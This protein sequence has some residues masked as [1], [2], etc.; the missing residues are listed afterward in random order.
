VSLTFSQLIFHSPTD[1]QMIRRSAIVVFQFPTTT[2]DKQQQTPFVRSFV[3]SFLLF[4]FC[5][6]VWQTATSVYGST[7]SAFSLS[8]LPIYLSF[9]LLLLFLDSLLSLE[10]YS[11][12]FFPSPKNQIQ[13]LS[14]FFFS[15]FFGQIVVATHFI[16]SIGAVA[17]RNLFS[18]ISFPRKKRREEKS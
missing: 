15:S 10:I 3:R 17:G 9:F 16:I 7:H 2:I 11:N 4:R 1:G 13:F 18:F 6:F 8:L 12:S 5:L 14:T